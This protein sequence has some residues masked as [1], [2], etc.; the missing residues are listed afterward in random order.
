[1]VTQFH[2]GTNRPTKRLMLQVSSLSP[3]RNNFLADGTLSHYKARL[4]ANSS[5]HVD[6]IDVDETFSLVVK[7][8]TI[9][10]VLS[11]A[12]S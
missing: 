4:V 1:M 10:T 12:V 2:V 11:L 8:G 7:P 5:T 3:L 9:Q 6:R